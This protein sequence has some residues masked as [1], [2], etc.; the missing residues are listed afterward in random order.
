MHDVFRSIPV[1]ILFYFILFQNV[2]FDS[3][4]FFYSLMGYNL[5]LKNAAVDC[6]L[7]M[8]YFLIMNLLGKYEGRLFI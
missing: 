4:K 6:G 2:G 1:P 3:L 8:I 7:Y 5:G